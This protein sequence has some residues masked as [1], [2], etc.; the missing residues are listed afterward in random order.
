MKLVCPRKEFFEA[1]SAA[2]A[3]AS[4]RTSVNI[5]QYLKIEGSD[6]S[7]RVVGCD[8]EMW[9]EREFA[10]FVAEPGAICLQAKL[11]Q[12]IAHQMP[13]GDL[14]LTTLENGSVLLQQGAAEYRMMSLDSEDFPEPPPFGGEGELRVPMGLLRKAVDSVIYA[15]TP[16]QHK[17]VLTGVLFSYNG[18]VLTLV[19]TDTHR[20]AVRKIDQEGI[21]SSINAVVPEKALRAIKALPIPDDSDVE[22]RFGGG[23]LGVESGSAT[24]VSQL[25]AGTYPNWERVVPSESTR[26]WMVEVDQLNEKVKRMMI[27]ARD[28]A[29]RVRFKG[30]GDQILMAARSEEKGEAK[31]EL[32]MIPSNGEVE[33]AF[34]GK[35]V[36]DALAAIDGPGVRIEMTESSRPAVFRPADDENGYF[37]VIMPMALA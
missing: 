34:N 12:D 1:V 4:V 31:E 30:E 8:G 23:R 29:N 16:E 3:A 28:N 35:Y 14:E 7:V 15:V 18:R 17:A 22:I 6:A 20:L 27:L 5:L 26:T 25:L 37:C 2:T 9:V 32:L 10:A 19:A 36:I 13:D 24:V 21:G 33:I 11:L